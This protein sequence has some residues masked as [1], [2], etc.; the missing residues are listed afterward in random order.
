M[1]WPKLPPRVHES[2]KALCCLAAAN[3]P[4]LAR[5]IAL[6]T[7]LPPAQ[8]AKVLQLLT[9]GGFV[10]SQRGT[11]G[12]FWLAAAARE[13]RVGDVIQFFEPSFS[14]SRQPEDPIVE[15]LAEATA[16]CRR[17]IVALTIADLVKATE[18]MR[19]R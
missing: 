8:T 17:K 13:I 4:M 1:N 3:Q 12:G 6:R 14:E 19:R 7:A 15:L 11:R 18:E 9:W 16:T 5:D 10:K 2:L